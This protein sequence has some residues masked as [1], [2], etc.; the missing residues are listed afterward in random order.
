MSDLLLYHDGPQMQQLKATN[1][2]HLGVRNLGVVE[3]G[4]SGTRSLMRLQSR[5]PLGASQPEV[6]VGE[7]QLPGSHAWLLAGSEDPFPSSSLFLMTEASP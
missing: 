5:C 4:S 7:D 1:I 2:C 6:T 3:L